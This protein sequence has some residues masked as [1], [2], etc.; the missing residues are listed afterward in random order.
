M[1]TAS[2]IRMCRIDTCSEPIPLPLSQQGV[3]LLHYLDRAFTKVDEALALCQRGGTPDAATLDWLLI[4]GD[5]AVGLLSKGTARSSE[6]RGRLLE[7]LLCL[8]NVRECMRH[9]TNSTP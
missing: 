8:A 9:R 1:G 5:F 2:Q 4:Q 7:F 3:C 6:Q